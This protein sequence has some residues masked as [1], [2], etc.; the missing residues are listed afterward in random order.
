MWRVGSADQIDR[1]MRAMSRDAPNLSWDFNKTDKILREFCIKEGIPFLSLL[2]RFQES[3]RKS[4][5]KLHF[6][7]DMHLNER[8]HRV[9]AD[10]IL[11]YLQR[12]NMISN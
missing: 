12:K 11:D 7:Y 10:A 6:S 5:E 9:A 1:R 3:Y 4:G 2:P 8:G